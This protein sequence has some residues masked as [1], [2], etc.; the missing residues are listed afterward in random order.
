[1]GLYREPIDNGISYMVCI[2]FRQEIKSDVKTWF[3]LIS[4]EKRFLLSGFCCFCFLF[5]KYLKGVEGKIPIYLSL[6]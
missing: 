1:M 5:T 6:I 3:D 2:E 4:D